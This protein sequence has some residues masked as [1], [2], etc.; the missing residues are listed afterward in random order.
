[1]DEMT[2]ICQQAG[3]HVLAGHAGKYLAA[4]AGSR[5]TLRSCDASSLNDGTVC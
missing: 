4:R 2:E 5:V 1:M 3:V